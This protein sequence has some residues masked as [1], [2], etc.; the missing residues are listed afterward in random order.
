MV[1]S[2]TEEQQAVRELASQI[3]A[4][5]A[6]DE[7]IRRSEASPEGIDRELWN[8][9]AQANLLGLAVSEAHGGA[10]MG[11]TETALLLAEQGRSVTQ[12]PL[13]ASIVM[14]GMPIA[15]FGSDS[16]RQHYLPRLATGEVILTAALREYAA[17]DPARPRVSAK[18]DGDRW[19]LD[20]E[21]ICVPAG[22]LAERILVPART[23]DDALGWR[24]T[25]TETGLISLDQGHSLYVVPAR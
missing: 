16:Q 22:H 5:H 24:I 7:R 12:A 2:F 3:F 8:A 15:E 6:S 10:G 17:V 11:L 1:F 14:A 9:L 19:L 21:K 25:T 13:L 18:A 20:G 23:R 4:D